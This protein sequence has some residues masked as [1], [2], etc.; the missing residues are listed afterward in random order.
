VN[1]GKGS[2]HTGLMD[3]HYIGP[4]RPANPKSRKIASNNQTPTGWQAFPVVVRCLL[5]DGFFAEMLGQHIVNNDAI[6][7]PL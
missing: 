7:V 5:V 1:F 2:G 6:L 3:Q 4:D